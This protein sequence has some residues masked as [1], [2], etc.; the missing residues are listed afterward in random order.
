MD[1]DKFGGAEVSDL[2][3]GA[4]EYLDLDYLEERFSDWNTKSIVFTLGDLEESKFGIVLVMIGRVRACVE[5]MIKTI[6]DGVFRSL[7]MNDPFDWLL[8]IDD[9]KIIVRNIKL[10]TRAQ[11]HFTVVVEGCD[12]MQLCNGQR[13]RLNT[14]NFTSSVSAID[15][16][17]AEDV[18]YDVPFA[19][20]P[21]F[22]LIDLVNENDQFCDDLR[23]EL[24]LRVVGVFVDIFEVDPFAVQYILEDSELSVDGAFIIFDNLTF[25]EIFVLLVDHFKNVVCEIDDS[26]I[27]EDGERCCTLKI[28]V[29]VFS[30]L[31]E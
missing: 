2:S 13:G 8:S 14:F 25:S 7:S 17:G 10:D 4:S 18:G 22:K 27:G 12:A 31:A 29:S 3:D 15:P 23:D 9:D 1:T 16:V 11:I 24:L 20:L 28:P 5:A 26:Q 21:T 6:P 19:S 30:V